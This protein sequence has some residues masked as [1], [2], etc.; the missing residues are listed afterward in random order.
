MKARFL[1]VLALGAMLSS[2]NLFADPWLKSTRFTFNKPVQVPGALL[3]AGTYVFERLDSNF[4]RGVVRVYNQ[5][6]TRTLAT[7]RIVSKEMINVADTASVKFTERAGQPP[8]IAYITYPGDTT[9]FEFL[10]GNEKG[11]QAGTAIAD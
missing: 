5:D 2:A 1:S 9:G 3:S 7:F 10:Y 4:N 8:A 6:K 11:A